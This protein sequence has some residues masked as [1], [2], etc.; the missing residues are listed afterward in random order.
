M[1]YRI[2]HCFPESYRVEKKVLYGWKKRKVKWVDAVYEDRSRT[3]PYK[4]PS[5]SYAVWAIDD[6]KMDGKPVDK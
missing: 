3:I 4:Y 1:E 2:V 6:L 5:Y